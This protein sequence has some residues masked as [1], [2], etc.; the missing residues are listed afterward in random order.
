MS[1]IH[2]PGLRTLRLAIWTT[3]FHLFQYLSKGL[4]LIFWTDVWVFFPY[5]PFKGLLILALDLKVVP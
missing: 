4:D 1:K 3:Y 2:F 5:F